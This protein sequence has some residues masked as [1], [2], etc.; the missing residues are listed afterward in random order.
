[1]VSRVVCAD[2]RGMLMRLVG[3]REVD[4]D[5]NGCEILRYLFG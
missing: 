4:D 3:K 1:M 2:I 5:E